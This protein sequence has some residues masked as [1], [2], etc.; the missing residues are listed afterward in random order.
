M[1]Q[2]NVALGAAGP[3]VYSTITLRD[4]RNRTA[5]MFPVH[6]AVTAGLH[7][8]WWWPAIYE[9]S[10]LTAITLV[11]PKC[12]RVYCPE[13]DATWGL[14]H[15]PQVYSKLQKN[16]GG[17]IR[18]CGLCM[19]TI[20]KE[21]LSNFGAFICTSFKALFLL[22][23]LWMYQEQIGF[24]NK[25]NGIYRIKIGAW[26][27]AKLEDFVHPTSPHLLSIILHQKCMLERQF[28]NPHTFKNIL[29]WDFV[30]CLILFMFRPGW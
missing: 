11:S 18:H 23:L 17:A 19:K 24:C 29:F 27:R 15:K 25:K 22:M 7:R 26:C 9:A 16:S 12:K 14:C 5:I 20:C 2:G 8:S 21:K 1:Q 30:A 10:V 13:R 4:G 3:L 28:Q 6:S